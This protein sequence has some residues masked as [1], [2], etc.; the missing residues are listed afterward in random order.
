MCSRED[1]WFYIQTHQVPAVLQRWAWRKHRRFAN[2]GLVW[3]LG[4]VSALCLLAH[5]LAR[6]AARH[7]VPYTQDIGHWAPQ[8]IH[9]ARPNSFCLITSSRKKKY[10]TGVQYINW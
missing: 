1:W 2:E 4:F 7:S 9:A 5:V 10:L 8:S 6:T 3:L